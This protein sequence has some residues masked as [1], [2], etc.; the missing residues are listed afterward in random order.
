[1][2]RPHCSACDKIANASCVQALGYARLAQDGHVPPRDAPLQDLLPRAH[3]L[4]AHSLSRKTLKGLSRQLNSTA[5]CRNI[6]RGIGAADLPPLSAFPRAHRVTYTYYMAVF[7]FLREDY[8][9]AEK[10]FVEALAL[11]HHK[12]KRNIECVSGWST[13]T[14][15]QWCPAPCSTRRLMDQ[16]DL[17]LTRSSPLPRR[18][19]LD[20]LIPL[21]LLR[22]VF[23]SRKLLAKS[24][25]HKT[26]YGP[27]ADA[28][29]SG[30]VAAYDRQLERAEKRLMER[31]TYL[32]VERAREGAVRGLLKKACVRGLPLAFPSLAPLR[33]HGAG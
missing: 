17:R 15:R 24:A 8:A 1:M 9:D 31:G 11:T 18:L 21:L 3:P 30:N 23:P 20:Y 5:L 33:V 6:I 29:K 4:F 22:G 28:I 27:F 16:D 19:I 14:T 26:L 2:R 32:V 10:R 7:A 12:M 13:C 25:R